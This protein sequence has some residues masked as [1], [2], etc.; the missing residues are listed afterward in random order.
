MVWVYDRTGGS[1]LLTMVMHASLA[2]CTLIL[3]PPLSVVANQIGGFATA[4]AFWA[5]VGVVALTHGG[6]LSP[7]AGSTP[8][9]PGAAATAVA[10][11]DLLARSP[12]AGP[13]AWPVP[14]SRRPS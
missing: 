14:P 7:A 13:V 2:G 1:L 10:P 8:A 6:H 11:S 4:A 12:G 3:F 9:V 5:V